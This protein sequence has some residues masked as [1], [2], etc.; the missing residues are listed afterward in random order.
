M[1]GTLLHPPKTMLEVWETLPEGTLCQLINNKLVMSPAP[2]DLHQVVLFDIAFAIKTFLNKKKS[3]ELRIAPYDV[4]FSEKNI[5]QPDILFIK[6]AKLNKIESKGLIGAPDV[7]IEILSYNTAQWDYEE[8]KFVYEKFGVQEYFIV[9]PNSKS[10]SAFYLEDAEYE[11]Q[12]STTGEIKSIVLN[13]HI[14]F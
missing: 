10:V 5:L 8:K 4:Y 9:D 6:N 14:V 11:E 1:P 12:E 2:K 13:T 7:V 3:G